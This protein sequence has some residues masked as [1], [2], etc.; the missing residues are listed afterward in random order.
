MNF[1]VRG[2]GRKSTG[3]ST[4]KKLPKSSDLLVSASGVSKTIFLSSDPD[5]LCYRLTLL[6]QQKK[7]VIILKKLLKKLLL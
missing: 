6:L 4:F 1:D 3:D 5:E 2:Q 7:L